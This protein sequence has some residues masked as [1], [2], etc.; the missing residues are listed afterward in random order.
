M[1]LADERKS[2]PIDANFTAKL[3]MF[4]ILV[5]F[6]SSFTSHKNCNGKN[7]L[8]IK[9]HQALAEGED[10]FNDV[11]DDNQDGDEPRGNQ[12]MYWSENDRQ[13]IG[14]CQGLIKAAAACLRKLKSAVKS[15]GDFSTP[16]NVSQLD[17]LADISKE[18]SPG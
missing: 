8:P 17:D 15:N 6:W 2:V 4:Y 13:V 3:N 16:Q 11:L 9:S 1:K 10:P 12:D 14:A 18:I 5:W 7:M